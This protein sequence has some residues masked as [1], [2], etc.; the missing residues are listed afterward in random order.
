MDTSTHSLSGL[1][2]QLGLADEPA[3]IRAFI[4]SH[5][6]PHGAALADAL[7]WTPAKPTSCA[8]PWPRTRT[9]AR[10]WMS[11]RYCCRRFRS[12]NSSALPARSGS[13]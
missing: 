12:R 5:P 4:A 3:A 10:R 6:L 1:F 7:F 13:N 8:R 2:R 11:W 9:G